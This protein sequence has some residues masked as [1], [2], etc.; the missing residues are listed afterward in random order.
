MTGQRDGNHVGIWTC[1]AVMIVGFIAATGMFIARIWWAFSLSAA[2]VVAAGSV[3]L[4]FGILQDT[5]T[6][7]LDQTY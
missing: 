2:A 1:V 4:K 6:G 7:R 5:R 3:S